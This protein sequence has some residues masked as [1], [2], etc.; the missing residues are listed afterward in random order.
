MISLPSSED[1]DPNPAGAHEWRR[2]LEDRAPFVVACALLLFLVAVYGLLH[3][4]VFALEEL[5]LDTA[6]AMTLLLAATG[7]TIVLLRGG[8][9]LSIG[10][11]ISL[12]TVLAST[13]FGN[14]PAKTTSGQC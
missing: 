4:N 1:M 11:M 10:G 14:S 7:Q 8:I 9:N 2:R 13:H 3:K 12:G 6:A 5:N